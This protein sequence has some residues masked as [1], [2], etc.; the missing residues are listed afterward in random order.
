MI[1]TQRAQLA[2]TAVDLG[3]QLI[4][5]A[6]ARLHSPQPRFGK[7]HLAQPAAAFDAKKV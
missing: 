2:L 3:I 4:D 7:V 5:E 6:Q 1:G